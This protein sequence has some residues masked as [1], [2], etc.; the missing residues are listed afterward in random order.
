MPKRR[1]P[2][3]EHD[4]SSLEEAVRP[5]VEAS[6]T[7]SWKHV[8]NVL[9][10]NGAVLC[11]SDD[12]QTPVVVSIDEDP[13]GVEETL[14]LLEARFSTAIT[15]LVSSGAKT[16]IPKILEDL[17]KGIAD[18]KIQID[19]DTAIQAFIIGQVS[20]M[21]ESRN[22]L[23][24][25]LLV[26]GAFRLGEV[27]AANV[28][29]SLAKLWRGHIQST[30]EEIDYQDMVEGLRKLGL[31]ESRLQV[32]IC[33]NCANYKLVVSRFLGGPDAC[34][35]CGESWTTAKLYSFVPAYEKAKLRNA[36][37]ALFISSYLRNKVSQLAPLGNLD[38][39]PNATLSLKGVR[40]EVD[41]YLPQFNMGIECKIFENSFAP[42]TTTRLGSIKGPLTK[43]IK[44]YASLGIKKIGIVTN[45]PM[46]ANEKLKATLTKEIRPGSVAFEMVPGDVEE[47]V[48]WLD[49]LAT[50][51]AEEFNKALEKSVQ[52]YVKPQPEL[53]HPPPGIFANRPKREVETPPTTSMSGQSKGPPN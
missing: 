21:L 39:N 41:V 14:E 35:K 45:L 9:Y 10:L 24:N 16:I 47:L 4:D 33:P 53:R 52:S 29:D 44:N 48:K 30:L 2:T 22:N 37:L 12:V 6:M 28:F 31:I 49:L 11:V 32:S 15:P 27:L 34:P 7:D 17:K 38:V 19:N 43:Q 5:L 8:L 18:S 26:E 1:P 13:E 51:I 23:L 42:M 36:D 20:Q 25:R 46:D 50:R 40:F 3:V